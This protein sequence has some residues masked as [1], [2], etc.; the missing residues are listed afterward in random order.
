M[1]LDACPGVRAAA[2]RGASGEGRTVTDAAATDQPAVRDRRFVLAYAALAALSVMT[3]AAVAAAHGAA[4]G[5][6]SRPAG[7]AITGTVDTAAPSQPLEARDLTL[8]AAAFAGTGFS[9]DRSQTGAT[10]LQMV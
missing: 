4:S 5:T 7:G 8:P 6:T 3:I 10:T 2:R 1:N 9:L